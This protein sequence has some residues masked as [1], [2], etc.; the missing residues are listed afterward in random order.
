MGIPLALAGLG[1]AAVIRVPAEVARPDDVV[2]VALLVDVR[3]ADDASAGRPTGT[4]MTIRRDER[5]TA[6]G[7]LAALAPGGAVAR[8][9]AP[10]SVDHFSVLDSALLMGAGVAPGRG[11]AADLGLSASLRDDRTAAADPGI[12]LYVFDVVS[13]RDLAARRRV[14]V[15]GGLGPGFTL[16][17]PDDARATYDATSPPPDVVVLAEACPIASSLR[18]AGAS[19]VEATTVQDA[20]QDLLAG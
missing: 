7:W 14:L 17:C 3:G 9:K 10:T 1:L 2:D 11:R 4:F 12:L 16:T 18:G 8:A 13:P 20:V 15:L 5:P 6:L 19:L